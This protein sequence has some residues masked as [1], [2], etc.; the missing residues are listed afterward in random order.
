MGDASRTVGISGLGI[1][2]IVGERNQPHFT[3]AI[4]TNVACYVASSSA[5]MCFARV[6]MP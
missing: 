3:L 1:F 4:V 5:E 2:A 6:L